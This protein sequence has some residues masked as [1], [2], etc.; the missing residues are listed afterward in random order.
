MQIKG[1]WEVAL[2]FRAIICLY[3]RKIRTFVARFITM[4]RSDIIYYIIL[5]VFL[6]S[7]LLRKRKKRPEREQVPQPEPVTQHAE[8]DDF[9]EWFRQDE[10]V[11][12]APSPPVQTVQQ[13]VVNKVERQVAERPRPLQ[14]KFTEPRN[15]D[16]R[17]DNNI[18]VERIEIELSTA[19]DA[20]RAFIYSEIFQRKY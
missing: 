1:N 5:A 12:V 2:F 3:Q 4:E 11:K 13:S 19:E 17:A 20:R 8:I 9:D 6:L 10:P 16:N 14:T 15:L 18:N 7:G